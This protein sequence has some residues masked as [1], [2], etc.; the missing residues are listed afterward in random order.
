MPVQRFRNDSIRRKI[1]VRDIY[2]SDRNEAEN[3]ATYDV[4]NVVVVYVFGILR[5]RK[6]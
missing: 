5:P 6:N 4:S 3:M 2:E 1:N